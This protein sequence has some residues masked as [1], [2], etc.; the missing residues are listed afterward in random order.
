MSAVVRLVGWLLA[1]AVVVLPLV[2]V[3]A[4]WMAPER[5]PLRHLEV[6]AEYRHVSD[7]QIRSVVLE[8]V[9]LGY[10]DTDPGAVRAAL[11][12]LP[13][14]AEAEVR[15]RWP[16]R[17]EVVL[18]EHRAT[19]RW[20][21]DRLLSERGV[22]FAAEPDA[23]LQ[24][25]PWL[26]G[27]DARR[28]E[29]LEFY[30]QAMP[31]LRGIGQVPAGARLSRR[32]SWSLQLLDGT[33]IV[34]G[35]DPAPMQRLARMARVLPQ[36]M[37][38]EVRAPQRIDLRYPNGFAVRWAEPAGA[39]AEAR[40]ARATSVQVEGAGTRPGPAVPHAPTPQTGF[41]T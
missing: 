22:L 5:W 31:L 15:K 36:L 2:A 41:Q 1:L 35:R 18:R 11:L 12:A 40:A 7:Q 28:A 8:H 33:D 3:L 14:V 23:A 24:G 9:G 26:D 19:A 10:F 39:D 34:I 29:V 27:P 21:E 38:G 30:R 37:L 6:L 16:D 4:G 32:G 17:I 13:W 25:L 20:G